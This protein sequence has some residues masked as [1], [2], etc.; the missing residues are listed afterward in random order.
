MSAIDAISAERRDD[1]MPLFDGF[2]CWSRD[3]VE[4][5]RDW[6]SHA[7]KTRVRP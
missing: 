6:V 5:T 7:P 2:C 4:E 1:G 3:A